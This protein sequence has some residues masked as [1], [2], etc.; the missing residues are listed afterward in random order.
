MGTIR[1][2]LRRFR[3]S[4]RVNTTLEVREGKQPSEL[5]KMGLFDSLHFK[6]TQSTG[7]SIRH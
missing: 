3:P 7:A 5:L 2:A 6:C 4:P 1:V